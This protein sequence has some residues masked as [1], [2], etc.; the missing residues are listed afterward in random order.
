MIGS[1]LWALGSRVLGS[2]P[3][4][5]SRKPKAE[6]HVLSRASIVTLAYTA[7]TLAMT[8]PVVRGLAKNVAFDLGD[9]LLNMW[10]LAWDCTKILAILTGRA[11]VADFFNG[12]IF[13][14]ERLTLAYSEHLVAQAIQVLPVYA[15]THNPIL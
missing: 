7:I 15:V 13:Y 3:S 14:P 4:P 6:G 2:G 12:N 11:R 8:W 9:S 5:E 1:E 10:S